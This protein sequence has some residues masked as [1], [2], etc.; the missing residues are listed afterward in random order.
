MR[1][2]DL[3]VYSTARN[4][5]SP[6]LRLSTELKDRI[7][8]FVLGGRFI[9][10]EVYAHVNRSFP[11]LGKNQL[12]EAQNSTRPIPSI[13]DNRSGDLSTEELIA[14][15]ACCRCFDDQHSSLSNE[16]AESQATGGSKLI[17]R[18]CWLP[19]NLLRACRETYHQSQPIFYRTNTFL[20]RAPGAVLRFNQLVGDNKTS[21]HK[22]HL[23]IKI[24][25]Q[26]QNE[27][28]DEALPTIVNLFP[29]LRQLHISIKHCLQHYV[30]SGRFP[31]HYW[32]SYSLSCALCQE[33]SKFL[34][35]ARRLSRLPLRLLTIVLL[36]SHYST[37]PSISPEDRWKFDRRLEGWISQVRSHVL[38]SE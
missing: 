32:P 6:L 12:H 11:C 8:F 17:S 10:V 16:S 20:I 24:W 34:P 25:G 30:T 27:A 31:T 2:A 36:V 7:Y 37:G 28:W 22:I 9:H 26:E 23:D 14:S 21:V 29:K 33:D 3:G 19:A 38:N 35:Q 15:Q 1:D 13:S 4:A 18:S 5:A